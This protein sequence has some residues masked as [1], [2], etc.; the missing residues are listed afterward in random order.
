MEYRRTV[1]TTQNLS[2]LVVTL[3]TAEGDN[4]ALSTALLGDAAKVISRKLRENDSIYILGVGCFGAVL[5]GADAAF[6]RHVHDRV[7][8]GLTDA[9][10]VTNRFSYKIE[11]V[12]Y[13]ADASS[14]HELEQAV[15]A[16]IPS[17]NLMRGMVQA[18]M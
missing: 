14:A 12:N 11:V 2:I 16:M 7:A 3:R 13:P 5:P 8:E 10:G 6:A 9:A 1:A 18:I 15:S 17:D 4:L